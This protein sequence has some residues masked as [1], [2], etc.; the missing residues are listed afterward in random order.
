MIV[1]S[2]TS[3]LNYLTLIGRATLLHDLFGDV[4][5]PEAVARELADPAAPPDVRQLISQPPPWL[6]IMRPDQI[7]ASLPKLGRGETEAISLAQQ[8]HADLLL[9]DDGDARRAAA[10]RAIRVTGTL[11]I[12]EL[13]ASR[14][15]LDLA[16]CVSQLRKTTLR[17]PEDVIERMLADDHVR[18]RES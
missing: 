6:R 8:I 2:D 15:L 4:I 16:A 17:M 3:P 9:C 10:R 5:V 14:G 11:G 1:I 18:D 7:D 12:L 13:G